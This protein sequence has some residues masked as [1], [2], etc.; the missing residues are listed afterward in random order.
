MGDFFDN[1]H[2]MTILKDRRRH[3]LILSLIAF[4]VSIFISSPWIMKPKFKASAIVYPSNLSS[5]GEESPTEQLL[6]L[7][8]SEEINKAM[9]SKF[10]LGKHYDL[11]STDQY[12]QTNLHKKFTENVTVEKTEYEAVEVGV[13]DHKPQIAYEMT[14]EMLNLL[15][16]TVREM[17]KKKSA[18]ILVIAERQ[19][20]LKK[21]EIDSLENIVQELRTKYNILDYGIQVK[22]ATRKYYRTSGSDG[23]LA[24]ATNML[25]NLEQKGE[26]YIESTYNL[27]AARQAAVI[28]KNDVENAKKE[29]VKQLSF[30]DIVTYPTIPDKKFWPVRWVI[31]ST[32]TLSTLFAALVFFLFADQ[33]KHRKVVIKDVK[34]E[35]IPVLS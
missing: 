11:D 33:S 12:Y 6:Q 8:A 20:N 15:N 10:N 32:F 29:L 24:D 17:H 13:V 31:V 26:E 34:T 4:G 19:Y 5:Y 28:L 30:V 1:S 14:V 25:R 7:F 16:N 9:I 2:I 35:D 3:L 18:E 21:K 23:K 22:E 27:N